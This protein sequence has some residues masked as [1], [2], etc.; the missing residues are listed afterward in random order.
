[1]NVWILQCCVFFFRVSVYTRKSRNNASVLNFGGGFRYK[2]ESTGHFWNF[3]IIFKNAGK[4]QK[5]IKA[6]QEFLRKTSFHQIFMSVPYEFLNLYEICRKRE[7][8]QRND[9][10]LS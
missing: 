1:M 5:K 4:N 3:S 9:N 2:N 8:L 6:K 10:D 7:N